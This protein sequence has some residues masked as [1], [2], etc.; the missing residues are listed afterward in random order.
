MTKRHIYSLTKV[1]T[2]QLETY[3]Q[4]L[5]EDSLI[6]RHKKR[7]IWIFESEK[8]SFD[9]RQTDR[10]DRRQQL[11]LVDDNRN[12]FLEA[13]IFFRFLPGTSGWFLIRVWRRSFS[14]FSARMKSCSD[15]R[16]SWIR[17][18]AASLTRRSG[19]PS[20][21]WRS[22][23]KRR[24]T[25]LRTSRFKN[26]FFFHYSFKEIFHST[27]PIDGP[28]QTLGSKLARCREGQH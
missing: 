11:S 28:P 18:L 14:R 9:I 5:N 12:P 8:R 24:R 23:W 17:T 7:W 15:R 10:L 13:T 2:V 16:T 6:Q 22:T 27:F 4:N 19:R 3:R 1:S 21:C 25:I 20:C 26:S